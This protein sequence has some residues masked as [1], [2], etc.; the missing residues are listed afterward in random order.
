MLDP[1]DLPLR[2]RAT[3]VKDFD[4][5]TRCLVVEHYCL[6]RCSMAYV[7]VRDSSATPSTGGKAVGKYVWATEHAGSYS[8]HSDPSE[9]V[10]IRTACVAIAL[11]PYQ[12]THESDNIDKQIP[13]QSRKLTVTRLAISVCLCLRSACRTLA[14]TCHIRSKVAVPT[15]RGLRSLVFLE[16]DHSIIERAERNLYW[17]DHVSDVSV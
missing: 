10:D 4:L 11:I 1:S 13:L 3:S 8:L 2:S 7:S 15:P 16:S 12:L 9:F 17:M 6:L 14:A 5:I